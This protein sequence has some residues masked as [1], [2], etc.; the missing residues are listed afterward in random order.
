MRLPP[1]ID[2]SARRSAAAAVYYNLANAES[3]ELAHSS[4][5][6]SRKTGKISCR[7][8]VIYQETVFDPKSIGVATQ[9]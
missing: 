2:E 5:N 3:Q 7:P 8:P 9:V 6:I 4:C 1:M